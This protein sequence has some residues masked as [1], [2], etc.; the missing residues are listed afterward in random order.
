MMGAQETSARLITARPLHGTK[1]GRTPSTGDME[2]LRR[3]EVTPGRACRLRDATAEFA[4]LAGLVDIAADRQASVFAPERLEQTGG[5]PKPRI[6]RFVDVMF[7]ENVG[8]DEREL[9]NGLSEFRGHAS[10]SNGHEADSG[11]GARN[12]PPFDR[13]GRMSEIAD[14]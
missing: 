1:N 13:T 9:V 5:G 8:R 6:E 11:G 14:Y 4:A 2:D 7:L 12:L 3:E 10:R